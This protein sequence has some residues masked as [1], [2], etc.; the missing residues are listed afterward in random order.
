MYGF[1]YMYT[2]KFFHNQV[3]LCIYLLTYLLF[4]G[5]ERILKIYSFSE[6]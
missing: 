5:I 4:Y 2:V 1:I 3:N 6:L